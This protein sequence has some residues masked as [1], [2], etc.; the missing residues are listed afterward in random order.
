[1]ENSNQNSNVRKEL[2]GG[3]VTFMTMA[4]IIFVQP[5][6]LSAAGMDFG[7]VTFATC[8][9]AALATAIMG[10]Y[11]NL[12][13]AQAPGM[14]ENFFF[15]YTVVLTMGLAW[16]QAL[17]AVFIA[18]VVFL[19]LSIF[20]VRKYI[21]DAIPDSMKHAVAGGIGIFIA[22]IGLVHSGIVVKNP[23]A[24]VQVGDFHAPHTLLAL[25]GLVLIIIL[26]MRKVPGAI[27][28][29]IIG[30]AVVGLVVGLVKYEGILSAP[31]SP[32]P[33]FFK[34][35]FKNL[36]S[37]QFLTVIFIFLYMDLFDTVGTLLAVA[38][39]GNLLTPKGEIPGGNRA[40]I[41]D[42]IGTVVGAIFGTSTVTS[43]IESTAGITAGARKGLSSI[44]IAILFLL[45]LFFY[46]LIKMVGAGVST[47]QDGTTFYPITASALIVVGALMTKTLSRIEWK[48]TWKAIPAFLT[49]I[50][51][52]L[53]YSIADGFALGFVAY[54][55]CA[56]A[57]GKAKQINPAIWVIAILFVIRYAFF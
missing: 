45:S 16:Q 30:T 57:A 50:G 47:G 15:T 24:L 49:I 1:M 23:S 8:I 56:T 53:T 29:G 40:L 31:P 12:P 28:W 4:Y 35:S 39:A 3:L 36:F 22:F 54:P 26:M 43:F 41:S 25:F 18:G 32:A 42:A 20:K 19:I 21:V 55:I 48:T 33:T 34:M 10:I 37:A 7:A 14:G 51:I 52:P 17:G 2:T 5:A 44:F 13:V 27:L 38:D 9:S 11:A 6:V 46:P